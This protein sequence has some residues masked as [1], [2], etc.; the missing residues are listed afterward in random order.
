MNP[1]KIQRISCALKPTPH[2]FLLIQFAT[3]KRR[4]KGG[5]KD[6]ALKKIEKK[7]RP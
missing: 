6:E 1:V 5:K 7:K 2:L 4:N 3:V